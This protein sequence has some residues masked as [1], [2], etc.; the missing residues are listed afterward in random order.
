MYV[1]SV[2]VINYKQREMKEGVD[3]FNTECRTFTSI[4]MSLCEVFI[5]VNS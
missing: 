1:Y 5:V 4:G 2:I 3:I